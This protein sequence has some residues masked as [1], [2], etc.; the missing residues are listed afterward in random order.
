MEGRGR[1]DGEP[2]KT[3]RVLIGDMEERTKS[4]HKNPGIFFKIFKAHKRLEKT[5]EWVCFLFPS[6][7]G[8]AG[9]TIPQYL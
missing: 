8:G 4:G 9:Q 7:L 3:G 2:G 1:S 5:H 6:C